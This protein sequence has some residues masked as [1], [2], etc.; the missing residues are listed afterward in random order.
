M[1]TRISKN[2]ERGDTVNIAI[3]GETICAYEGETLATVLLLQDRLA[4]YETASGH[5]RAPFCNMGAC[6]ECRVHVEH[7]GRRQWVLACMTTIQEN[8]SVTTGL[9]LPVL[10]NT[11]DA[12]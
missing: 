12:S 3:N 5:K 1:A 7:D 6:Y 9:Q 10:G 8:M 2:V 4:F 11:P